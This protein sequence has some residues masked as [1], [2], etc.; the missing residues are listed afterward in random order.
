VE[1]NSPYC[2]YT[3]PPTATP[4]PPTATPLPTSTPVPPTATPTPTATATSVNI[5][6][7]NNSLDLPITGVEVD[8]IN[9]SHLQGSNL[10]LAAGENGIFQTTLT[11]SRTLRV[12]YGSHIPAQNFTV[13]D[14]NLTITCYDTNGSSGYT[15]TSVV[16]N[17]DGVTIQAQDGACQ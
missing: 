2:G 8:G 1:A 16:I 10:P 9:V 11:G 12:I 7:I 15:D 13:T 14:S 5:Q 4:V 6:V 17:I 3:P